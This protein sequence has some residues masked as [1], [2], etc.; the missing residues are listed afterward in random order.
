MLSQLKI[1]IGTILI[2]LFLFSHI[3]YGQQFNL[4]GAWKDNNGLTYC[5]NQIGNRLYWKMDDRPRVHNVFV[6]IIS[7]QYITGEW[8][9]LPGGQMTGNG[10]MALTIESNNRFVKTSQTSNYLGSVWT[11]V[12][13]SECS[14]IGGTKT[15]NPG[16]QINIGTSCLVAKP[17]VNTFLNKNEY[18][19]SPNGKYFLIMQE[20]GNLVL[21]RGSG[22]G[23]QHEVMWNSSTHTGQNTDSFMAIQEDGNLVVYRG[24]PGDYSTPAWNSKTYGQSGNYFLNVRDNG[25]IAVCKGTGPND[26][27]GE[28]WSSNK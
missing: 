14:K 2:S 22:P 28:I 16:G 20:D 19:V 12:D 8:S 27:Q 15:R 5:I 6:G 10:T 13:N 17:G 7:N 9:D 4:T 1:K 25:T 26:N 3:I 24:A 23:D 21:Y 11:R 18:M